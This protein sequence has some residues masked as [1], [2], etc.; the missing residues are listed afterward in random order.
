MAEH[1]CVKAGCLCGGVQWTA[2]AP[3]HSQGCTC[4]YCQNTGASWACC[5]PN[6]FTIDVIE[7]RVRGYQFDA[8]SPRHYYCS[9]CGTPLWTWTPDTRRTR[10]GAAVSDFENPILNWNVQLASKVI[11]LPAD[12]K[13]VVPAEAVELAGPQ[14]A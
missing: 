3:D 13:D 10:Y 7:S 1:K 4:G 5:D 6:E 11:E 8:F 12:L 14:A 9:S 2:P